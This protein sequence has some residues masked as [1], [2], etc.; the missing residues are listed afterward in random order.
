MKI[1]DEKEISVVEKVLVENTKKHSKDS[2][3]AQNS[4][5]RPV[6][7]VKTTH[8]VQ[9]G[10][11]LFTLS[12]LYGKSIDELRALNNLKDAKRVT[13]WPKNLITH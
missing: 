13:H 2:T 9:K 7:D 12:K 4:L 6:A 11:T 5:T 3:I 8:K 10:E 1:E